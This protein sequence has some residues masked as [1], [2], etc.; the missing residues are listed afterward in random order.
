MGS[1]QRIFGGE[2]EDNSE[3]DE[4]YEGDTNNTYEI[5]YNCDNCEEEY[6]DEYGDLPEIPKGTTVENYFKDK[7]CPN[8]GC[9]LI[10]KECEK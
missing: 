7:I 2:K 4:E 5:S 1:L 6:V 8:C 9:L 3:K 10:N